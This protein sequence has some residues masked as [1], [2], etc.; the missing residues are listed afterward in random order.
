MK[1]AR[2]RIKRAWRAILRKNPSWKLKDMLI[3]DSDMQAHIFFMLMHCPYALRSFVFFHA[4]S[5]SPRPCLFSTF[6]ISISLFS[7]FS[8]LVQCTC[9]AIDIPYRPIHVL[10]FDLDSHPHPLFMIYPCLC[11]I[12]ALDYRLSCFIQYTRHATIHCVGSGLDLFVTCHHH[13]NE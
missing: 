3:L 5:P 2:K 7:F 4:I 13:I 6:S 10:Y 12:F 1:S 9:H 8:L 11:S